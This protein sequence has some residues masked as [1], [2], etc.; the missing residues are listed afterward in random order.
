[1][2]LSY[3][4]KYF[5]DIFLPELPIAETVNQEQPTKCSY[6]I[7]DLSP[8]S[9]FS[10]RV[11]AVN[12]YGVGVPSQPSAYFK[13][14]DAAP[15]KAPD[16]ISNM[17]SS[18][19]TLA[20]TWTELKPEDLTGDGVGYKVYWRKKSDSISDDRW[21]SDTVTGRTNSYV[22]LVGEENFYL[23]YEVKVGAFNS[24]GNGPNTTVY[25]IMS[26]EAL[27]AAAPRNVYGYGYNATAVTVFWNR[28]DNT[29]QFVR[30]KLRG[31]RINYW[32]A[33]DA[34]VQR[35]S[36]VWCE[37]CTTALVVGLLPNEGYWV[38]VQAFNAAGLGP[39]GENYYMITLLNAPLRYPEY[40]MTT[41]HSN[42][43]V[44][45]QW[46]GVYVGISGRTAGW[47]QAAMVASNRKRSHCA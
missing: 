33:K 36:K 2:N 24:L 22:A 39:K 21:Q 7:T 40:V 19:G 1:M 43:S 14:P 38:N 35:F 20:F 32:L 47:L 45:V 23:E 34:S 37:S 41:S 18:M 26:A 10:F 3:K 30:G 15:R 4:P 13:I 46:R 5:Q 31:F 8:G 12:R 42:N 44:Q 27:P 29:R 16:T 9:S 11:S 28:L 25:I 17:F 6:I